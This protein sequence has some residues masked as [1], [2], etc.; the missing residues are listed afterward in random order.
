MHTRG[1]QLAAELIIKL[2]GTFTGKTQ[3]NNYKYAIACVTKILHENGYH[4]Y[5]SAAGNMSPHANRT[6]AFLS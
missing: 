2:S 1:N 6:C 3:Q 4:E 5:A